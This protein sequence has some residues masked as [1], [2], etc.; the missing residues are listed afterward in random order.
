MIEI[1]NSRGHVLHTVDADTLI[2]ADLSGL[3]LTDANLRGAD[4]SHAKLVKTNLAYAALMG[5]EFNSAHLEETN[6]YHA[7]LRGANFQTRHIEAS[8][9]EGPTVMVNVSF[10][11]AYLQSAVFCHC[12]LFDVFFYEAELMGANFRNAT[13]HE[14]DFQYADARNADFSFASFHKV[15]IA[16]DPHAER[17]ECGTPFFCGADFTHANFDD[18]TVIN[19]HLRNVDFTQLPTKNLGPYAKAQLKQLAK[20]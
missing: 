5:A 16:E 18:E 2:G 13:L 8:D 6:F 17:A 7:D 14:T 10:E 11:G 20:R 19:A 9:I 12:E 1:K 15:E 3:D 4:L